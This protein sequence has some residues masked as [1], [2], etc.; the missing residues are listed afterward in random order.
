MSFLSYQDFLECGQNERARIE[1]IGQA[2]ASHKAGELYRTAKDADEYDHQRNVGITRFTQ[3]IL[4]S[5]GQRLPN[6]SA[7]NNRITSNFFHKLN[8]QRNMY[9]L[10]NGVTFLNEEVKA[11]L[12][13]NFDTVLQDAGYKALIHGTSFIFWNVDTAHVF[14][15]TE[16]V[17]LWDEETSALAAGIRFWQIAANK[18]LIAI[19]YERDGWTRYRSEKGDY[20]FRNVSA[21]QPYKTKVSRSDAL[22]DIVVGVENYSELPI[23]PL[24]GS[25]LRQSTLCGIREAIDSFDLIRSGF[26]ND[27]QDCAQIYWIITNADGMSEQDLSNFRERLLFRHIANVDTGDG[28]S[29]TPYTQEIP[30]QARADYLD[31]IR[32]GIYEDF[33]GLDVSTISA[34]SRTA[35]EINAAYQAL[36]EAADD[37]EYQLIQAVE[38]LLALQGISGEDAVPQF[39]RNRIANQ[40]EQTTMVLQAAQYLDDETLLRHLPWITVDELKRIMERRETV[41]LNQFGIQTQANSVNEDDEAEE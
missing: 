26:A 29:V 5:R 35:T 11:K 24:W 21:R 27:L 8:V 23:V 34:A 16:F 15:V 30:Y 32:S 14:P 36:D 2:I 19:V 10:G 33:G 12:G 6:I 28:A 38:K 9:S 22:G 4:G 3:T 18:P 41:A 17:P 13:K 1:F 31:R 37:Y 7:S 40:L 25:K 39:K 20:R